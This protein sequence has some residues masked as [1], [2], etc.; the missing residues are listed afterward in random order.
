MGRKMTEANER[1]ARRAQALL[2]GGAPPREAA[3][4]CGYRRL[5]DMMSAIARLQRDKQRANA[6]GGAS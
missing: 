3:R 6:Q 1:R 4:E 2:A 5:S